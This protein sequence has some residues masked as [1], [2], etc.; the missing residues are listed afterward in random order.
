MPFEGC[1]SQ[2]QAAVEGLLEENR[3]TNWKI[4]ADSANTTV[5]LRFTKVAGIQNGDDGAAGQRFPPHLEAALE[6]LLLE[7]RIVNWG[8]TAE[9]T[10]SI[11]AVLRLK[12]VGSVQDEES[13]A[14]HPENSSPSSHSG[15]H[16]CGRAVRQR[17]QRRANIAQHLEHSTGSANNDP[18]TMERGDGEASQPS[19]TL[20]DENNF[21]RNVSQFFNQKDISDVVLKVGEKKFFGH[22]FVLAKS[23]E[24][25]RTIL[26]DKQVGLPE[27]DLEMSEECQLHFEPF[28]RFLYTAEVQICVNSA[29]GILCLADKYS[30]MSLKTLC[31]RYMVDNTQSP[32]V[33]NALNWYSWAKALHMED[34]VD[35]CTKTISWN[36]EHLFTLNEWLEMD[37]DFVADILSNP[38]LVVSNEFTLYQAVE[39][40]LLSDSHLTNLDENSKKLLPLVRFPQMMVQQVYKVETGELAQ[41]DGSK[42]L[43]EKLLHKAYRFRSLCP[44][45]A[46]LNIT[47]NEEFYRPRNYKD[48]TVDTVRMQNTLRFG[49]QVDVRTYVG[50]VPSTVREGEWKITYRKSNDSWTLQVY[51]HDSAMVNGEAR[52]Q[53]VLVI[54][55]DDDRVLLVE[56][57]EETVCSRGNHLTMVITPPS[58]NEANLMTV[59]IKPLPN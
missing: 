9:R 34:L 14:Q 53:V 36:M 58:N 17:E 37:I 49:I 4:S 45:Q 38:Q 27:I 51:C 40:W 21:I 28:L 35:S 54:S 10:G 22:K 26:Y 52:I 55:D 50:P 47:F 7:N 42:D 1:P 2:V 57:S 3:V 20:K 13:A 16:H 59:L 29:V 44:F 6:V 39:R 5:V 18:E 32:K 30:E 23:S 12:P 41:K 43:I 33:Q 46:D 8:R 25:F 24:V 19:R 31:T 56:A 11:T 15:R 48:L